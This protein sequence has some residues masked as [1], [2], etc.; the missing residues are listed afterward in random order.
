MYS[1]S[2]REQ[3][4][5]VFI[6]Q[7]S[8]QTAAVDNLDDFTESSE[9]ASEDHELQGPD[10]ENI[11]C[12]IE[13]LRL[14][15]KGVVTVQMEGLFMYADICQLALPLDPRCVT[16]LHCPSTP[17]MRQFCSFQKYPLD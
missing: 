5:I 15:C 3:F 7:D 2:I 9:S 10:Y 12:E 8:K 6:L 14:E 17:D 16:V 11:L 1:V 4:K 13:H